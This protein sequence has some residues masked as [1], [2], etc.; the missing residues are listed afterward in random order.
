MQGWCIDFA[1]YFT[2][3]LLL[4]WFWKLDT[5]PFNCMCL[6]CSL[7]VFCVKSPTKEVATRVRTFSHCVLF[8]YNIILLSMTFT[9]VLGADCYQISIYSFSRVYNTEIISNKYIGSEVK[10]V[11][12][13]IT[14]SCSECKSRLL[15]KRVVP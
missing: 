11:Q 10:I 12:R 1:N 15:F 2:N 9:P 6:K 3:G 14:L 8:K 4:L 13:D 7:Q 5:G